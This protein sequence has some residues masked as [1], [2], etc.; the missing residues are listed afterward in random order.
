MSEAI[1]PQRWKQ[2]R[3]LLDR[4]LD[5]EEGERA[6]F[7]AQLSQ[8]SA[9]LR[10]DLERILRWQQQTSPIDLP[11]AAMA[12][13]ALVEPP[14]PHVDRNLGRR[15]GAFRLT[16]DGR[17]FVRTV[18]SWFDAYLQRGTARHSAAV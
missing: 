8:Q 14:E 10:E 7:L 17:P 5:L 16:E 3:P 18:C 11:A 1:A 12:A 13:T 4:A 15:I 9:E 6:A 2:L